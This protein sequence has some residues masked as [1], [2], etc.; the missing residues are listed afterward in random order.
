MSAGLPSRAF[1]PSAWVPPAPAV[2]RANA[3]RPLRLVDVAPFPVLPTWAGGKLRIVELA[4]ALSRTGI[5]LT[6]V[7]P[8]HVTQHRALADCEPFKLRQ[9]PYAP[10]LLPFLFV[11]RPFPYGWLVS[12]HP[13]Y[14][15]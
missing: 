12:F 11:D 2:A 10:F 7:S 1:S 9:I 13:G 15:T 14:R 4:R 5:D 8:Y 3:T 6:V